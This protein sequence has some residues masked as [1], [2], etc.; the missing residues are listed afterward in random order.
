MTYTVSLQVHR[1]HFGTLSHEGQEVQNQTD[2]RFTHVTDDTLAL[3]SHENKFPRVSLRRALSE[4]DGSIFTI[5]FA[6]R[7]LTT[8]C[9]H[10]GQVLTHK[11]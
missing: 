6:F 3:S 1:R 10:T 9:N 11:A 4:H 7:G 2:S 5:Y 8:Y